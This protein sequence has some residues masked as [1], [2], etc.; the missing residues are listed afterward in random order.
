MALKKKLALIFVVKGYSRKSKDKQ[1]KSWWAVVHTKYYA[2]VLPVME[3]IKH[4]QDDYCSQ[5]LFQIKSLSLTCLLEVFLS[6]GKVVLF[7]FNYSVV[8][9]PLIA[10][11]RKLHLL[12]EGGQCL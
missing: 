2:T 8:S 3:I 1:F 4:H 10:V 9:L 6:Y 12:G 5:A 11:G 7:F